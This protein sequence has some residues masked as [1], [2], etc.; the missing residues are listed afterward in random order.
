VRDSAVVQANGHDT[1]ENE[2]GGATLDKQKRKDKSNW[3]WLRPETTHAWR[4]LTPILLFRA[5]NS[6]IVVAHTTFQV[7]VV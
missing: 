4:L 2:D 7:V 3:W 6:R 5:Y 1:R